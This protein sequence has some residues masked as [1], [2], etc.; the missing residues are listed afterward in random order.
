[1]FT[2]SRLADISIAT[3]TTTFI[4]LNSHEQVEV[5][6][7]A[8]GFLQVVLYGHCRVHIENPKPL[9]H[10]TILAQDTL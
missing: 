7:L 8:R 6:N 2:T 10:V 3:H 1:M 9:N 4:D 5:R